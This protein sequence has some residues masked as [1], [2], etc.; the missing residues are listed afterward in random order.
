MVDVEEES[1]ESVFEDCPND[2]S[3]KEADHCGD[4]GRLGRSGHGRRPCKEGS[5]SDRAEMLACLDLHE[6][7]PVPAYLLSNCIKE[8]VK[9][10]AVI[11][12]HTSGTTYHFVR[13]KDCHQL[14][15]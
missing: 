3:G 5:S 6:G 1:V 10:K 11:G 9:R 12:P 14:K 2:V 8:R 7:V 13:V 15:L 4:E